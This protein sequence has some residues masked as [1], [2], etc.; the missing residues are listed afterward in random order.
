MSHSHVIFIY[1]RT[2]HYVL[3][4]AYP[5]FTLLGQSLGSLVLAYDAFS[6][7]VPDVFVDTMG[8]A[9]SLAFAKWLFPT[10]PTAAYVHYPTI[11]TDML[12][13]LNAHT[14]DGL[15]AGAGKGWKGGLK[16]Q[17][18]L[19][20]AWMY[21][22]VGSHVDVVMTNS[23]WTQAHIRALWGP[24]RARRNMRWEPEVVFP[25]VAVGE[26]EKAIEI[27]E[28]SEA[29]R[30]PILLYIAQFRPEKNQ[31]L[32]LRAFAQMVR[33]WVDSGEAKSKPPKLVLLGSVRD[34][35]DEERVNDLVALAEEMKVQDQVEFIRDA[36]WP[37]ILGWLRK[38]SV[39]VNGMWNE[40]FGIGVVEYQAAGLICVVNNSGGPKED[41]VIDY[42]GGPT[43]GGFFFFPS[44][45][46]VLLNFPIFFPFPH[47]SSPPPLPSFFLSFFPFSFLFFSQNQPTPL[48]K[49]GFH[50][51]STIPA[52]ALQFA[53]ALSLPAHTRLEM[54]RRARAS[55]RRFS[56]EVFAEAW[57]G[58]VGRLVG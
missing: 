48:S 37:E 4:S 11:S 25:P 16:R 18:W 23:S 13:S 3:S 46:P 30:E 34:R 54:R 28:S 39:G 31:A 53:H 26:I 12:G 38:S 45:P 58:M 49:I 43:G 44:P 19:L 33:S 41:I 5:H 40:H 50:A 52:Y 6:L 27:S 8:Y 22:W 10:M 1:L 14:E 56:E 2:R 42:Q 24:W 15:N 21:G 17:Y 29:Q 9:F 32:V 57:I 35:D 36:T 47:P 55:A 7:L 51:A 20:F